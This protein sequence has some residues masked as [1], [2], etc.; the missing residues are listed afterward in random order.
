LVVG[1]A[2]KIMEQKLLSF[3][4]AKYVYLLIVLDSV[5][6]LFPIF[7]CYVLNIYEAHEIKEVGGRE[8]WVLYAMK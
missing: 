5:V 7:S 3:S 6:F 8:G 4:I 1:K 2:N